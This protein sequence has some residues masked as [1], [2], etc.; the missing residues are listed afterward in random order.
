MAQNPDARRSR[1]GKFTMLKDVD[2]HLLKQ[3]FPRISVLLHVDLAKT[4]K[5]NVLALPSFPAQA[6]RQRRRLKADFIN[7]DRRHVHP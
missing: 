3:V 5:N 4:G 2:S 1:A 6:N 7:N